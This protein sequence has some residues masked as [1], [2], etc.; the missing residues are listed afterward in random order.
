M[1]RQNLHPDTLKR[2]A[3]I[4][5]RMEDILSMREAFGAMPTSVKDEYD[6]LRGELKIYAQ[7]R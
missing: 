3:W 4:I 6:Q 2:A 1:E 5:R 7:A